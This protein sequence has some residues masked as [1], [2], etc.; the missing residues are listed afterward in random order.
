MIREK[1]RLTM[2]REEAEDVS[3]QVIDT[4]CERGFISADLLKML[5]NAEVVD[6]E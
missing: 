5:E 1:F 3:R 4:I 6:E 2:T